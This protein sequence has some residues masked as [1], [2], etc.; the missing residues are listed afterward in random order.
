MESKEMRRRRSGCTGHRTCFLGGSLSNR[1][2]F[3]RSALSAP[4][5]KSRCAWYH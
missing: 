4:L 2:Y 1:R 3:Q 5:A